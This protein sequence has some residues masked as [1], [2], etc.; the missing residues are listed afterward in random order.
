MRDPRRPGDVPVGL[1]VTGG[2]D[3]DGD[4]RPDTVLGEDHGDLVLSSDLD[5]DGLADQVLRVGPDGVVRPAVLEFPQVDHPGEAVLDG[6]SG[7]IELGS[8]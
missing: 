6:L 7:G 3:T 2:F 1:D 4:G 5:G 8:Q